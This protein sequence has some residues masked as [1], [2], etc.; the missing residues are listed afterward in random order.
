ML[1]RSTRSIAALAFA[2]SCV[3]TQVSA[4]SNSCS[5]TR[6]LNSPSLPTDPRQDLPLAPEAQ[7]Q[8]LMREFTAVAR[9]LWESKTDE[10]RSAVAERA[11]KLS[12]RFLE[13]VE[14]DP[15]SPVAFDCLVQVVAQEI[16]LENNTAYPG[17]TGESL[18]DKAIA[19]LL[20][21]HLGSEKLGE[22]CTR[23][24]YGFRKQCESF[25]RTVAE[26]STHKEVQ[27]LACL[28]LAQFLNGRLRRLDL[29]EG[30]PELAKRYEGLFGKDYL[31]ELR[32]KDRVEAIKEVESIFARAAERFGEVELPY[33]GTV[34]ATAKSEMLEIRT[35]SI[36]MQAPDIEGEDQDGGQFKL[37]DY[38][39]KVVLLYFWSEY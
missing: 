18:E 4:K 16:W 23:M 29:L 24:C 14:K 11:V 6:E 15:S 36:G 8:A 2:A 3:A 1:T 39:G 20:K 34:A 21:H 9:G 12:P 30:Q 22:A 38:R 7:Y 31:Q 17:R 26:T 35:L 28:R 10:D 13:L 19:L 27:G 5:A 25:L 32:L 37:S 33:G